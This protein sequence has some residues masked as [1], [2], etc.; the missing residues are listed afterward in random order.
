MNFT[1]RYVSPYRRY[2]SSPSSSSSFF[3]SRSRSYSPLYRRDQPYLILEDLYNRY[4]PSNSPPLRILRIQRF[5]SAEDL[6]RRYPSTPPSPPRDLE[7]LRSRD[8]SASSISRAS[9][10]SRTRI[11]LSIKLPD[12][13][14]F[15]GINRYVLF[16]NWKMRIQDKLTHNNDYYLT[17]LFKIAYII[18]RL[19]EDTAKYTSLRRR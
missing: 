2:S 13:P 11:S 19:D 5:L 15:N 8:I 10:I 16:D 9:P 3:R 1:S 18:I 4:T 14:V 17:E 6:S 12:P 7:A